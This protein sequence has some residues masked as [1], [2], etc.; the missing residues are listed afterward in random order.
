MLTIAAETSL[1][2]ALVTLPDRLPLNFDMGETV[3]PGVPANPGQKNSVNTGVTDGLA[4]V[5]YPILVATMVVDVTVV[6]I[7]VIE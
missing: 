2:S 1:P 5:I 7:C 6:G 4:I 3:A